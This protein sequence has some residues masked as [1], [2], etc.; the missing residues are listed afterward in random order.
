MWQELLILL[1][2]V[3]INGLFSGAEIATVTMRKTRIE[4]LVQEGNRAARAIVKLRASP[5]R[6][7]ATVQIGIT[8]VGAAAAAYGGDT[9]AMR[10]TPL[11]EPSL[12]AHAHQVAFIA[13]VAAISYLSLVLGEL[14]PKSLALRAAE[15]YALLVSRPLL[16]LATVARPIVWALTKSSNVV[17]KL[18]GDSTSFTES[19]MSSDELKAMLEDAGESGVLHPHIGEIAARAM[20]LNE[21]HVHDVMVPRTQLVA[22]SKESTIDELRRFAMTVPHA[23]IPLFEGSSDNIVGYISLRD[24]FLDTNAHGQT[25]VSAL[26]RPIS[27][28]PESMKAIDAL[29]TFQCRGAEIAIVVDEHGSTA[30][31][32]TR[33]DLAEELFGAAASGAAESDQEI[34]KQKDGSFVIVASAS[35]R[36]VNRH[37]DLNLP[38]TDEWNTVGGMIVALA[39]RILEKGDR[40]TTPDGSRIEVI[41]AS[42]RKVRA[43]RLERAAIA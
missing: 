38:E 27:F 12:G 14:V 30:G 42:P 5:E 11:L 21:L 35:V 18:F 22:M 37:L 25:R 32:L 13:V 17:L 10:L 29:Y 26:L 28:V 9:L 39:G 3:A 40:I 34:Q 23:R 41:D 1:A 20:D 24:A 19:R 43:I 36:S 6:F 7:L 2:L 8:V 31:L 4:Q 33:E 16:G 15:R